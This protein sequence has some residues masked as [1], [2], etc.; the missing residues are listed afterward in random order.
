MPASGDLNGGQNGCIVAIDKWSTQRK[1]VAIMATI[2][3]DDFAAFVAVVRAGSFTRAAEV[4]QVEKAQVSRRVRR[5]EVRLRAQLLVR[6]TRA[7][8]L[9]EV[10]RDVFGRATAILDA[11]NEAEAAVAGTR[12]EPQGLLRITCGSE[13]GLLAVNRWIAAYLARYPTVR[14]EADFT[15]RIT[16]IVSEG[17]DVAIRVGSL[18][19]SSLAARKLGDVSYALYAAPDY[20]AI[21]GTPG[22]PEELRRHA[23]LAGPG[24]LPW[25]LANGDARVDVDATPRLAISTNIAVRDAAAAALGIALLPRFQVCD[26]VTDGRLV[27]ILSGWTRTPVP[28]HAVYPP[29]RYLAP[30]VRAF[31]DLALT[32]FRQ[33]VG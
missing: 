9:T 24:G 7:L 3:L 5:L 29:T 20:L 21:S 15:N 31:V 19:S 25:A 11:V 4:L 13:F 12:A 16:D 27:E 23:L 18:P 22:S 26:L 8:S 14:I 28:V 10:G 6:T 32:M 2:E 33:T 17:F 30:K 1:T